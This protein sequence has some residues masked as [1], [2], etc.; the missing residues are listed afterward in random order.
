VREQL[1]IYGGYEVR[2][3][4]A[5]LQQLSGIDTH[6]GV[7]IISWS[8][9]F[10]GKGWFEGRECTFDCLLNF[11]SLLACQANGVHLA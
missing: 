8:A 7:F 4:I 6:P 5:N 2:Y 1:Y 11:S 9:S 10:E 3:W